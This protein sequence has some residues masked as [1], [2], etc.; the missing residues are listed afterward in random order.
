MPEPTPAASIASLAA[1]ADERRKTPGV[2]DDFEAEALRLE[3]LM[4]SFASGDPERAMI[5]HRYNTICA[6]LGVPSGDK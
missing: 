6:R 4:L 3:R 2:P 1:G 5:V